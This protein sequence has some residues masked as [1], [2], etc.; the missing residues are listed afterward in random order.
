M[1]FVDSLGFSRCEVDQAVCYQC[2]G[3]PLMI[4][5]VHVDDCTI[6]ASTHNL[7]DDFKARLKEYVEVTDLGE[8]HWL[9]GIE[10]QRDRPARLLRL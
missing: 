5:V 2:R 9:I 7:I 3:T 1:T 4:A 10:V 8:L 6:A